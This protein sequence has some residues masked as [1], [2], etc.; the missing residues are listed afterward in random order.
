MNFSSFHYRNYNEIC[1]R[2]MQKFEE[3]ETQRD[4]ARLSEREREREG[5][6]MGERREKKINAINQIHVLAHSTE[7]FL[8]LNYSSSGFW[9][10]RSNSLLQPLSHK[11]WNGACFRH[12]HRLPWIYFTYTVSSSIDISL[13]SL[14]FL[15]QPHQIVRLR[16]IE[17]RQHSK[18][19]LTSAR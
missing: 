9:L 7:Y 12:F 4:W 8:V 10:D 18:Q 2:W 11:P 16:Q 6:G 19:V 17:I 15:L 3:R 1:K 5:T 13:D 14:C